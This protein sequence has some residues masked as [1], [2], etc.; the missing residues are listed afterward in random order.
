M[1]KTAERNFNEATVSSLLVASAWI[2]EKELWEEAVTYALRSR[3]A[4]FTI[5]LFSRFRH[6]LF[7]G[8]QLQRL[9]R[10]TNQLP[11]DLCNNHLEILLSLAMLQDHKANFSAMPAISLQRR[12]NFKWTY[13]A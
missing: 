12:K 1:K 9:D 8:E 5:R 11:E 6:K 2:E 3:D 4:D 7:N 13:R 10:L